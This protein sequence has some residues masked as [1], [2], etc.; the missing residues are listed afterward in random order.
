MALGV[1]ER[2]GPIAPWLSGRGENP[3][4]PDSVDAGVGLVDVVQKR[5]AHRRQSTGLRPLGVLRRFGT[6]PRS[7]LMGHAQ[8]ASQSTNP[9]STGTPPQC[10][11]APGF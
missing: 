4:D 2:H 5:P 3:F 10:A 9:P 1:T 6:S 11:K 8:R 7:E